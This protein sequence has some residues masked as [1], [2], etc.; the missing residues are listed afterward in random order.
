MTTTQGSDVRGRV[1]TH[2]KLLISSLYIERVDRSTYAHLVSIIGYQILFS[3]VEISCQSHQRSSVLWVP[4]HLVERRNSS[5]TRQPVAFDDQKKI[6]SIG[7]VLAT[8]N[9]V[10]AE[11]I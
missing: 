11:T 6:W 8:S 10:L 5:S 4:A 2:A 3:K 1:L 9:V 7:I